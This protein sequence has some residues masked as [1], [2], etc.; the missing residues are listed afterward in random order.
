MD[1]INNNTE[2]NAF[3]QLPQKLKMCK[4]DC[5]GE[6]DVETKL[7]NVGKRQ[8][9]KKEVFFPKNTNTH[10]QFAFAQNDELFDKTN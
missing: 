2:K 5:A 6:C 8:C 4:C 1:R 10:L 3:Q 7:V 9:Q